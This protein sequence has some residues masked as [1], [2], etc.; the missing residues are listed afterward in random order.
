MK[1]IAPALRAVAVPLFAALLSTSAQ[2]ENLFEGLENL[3]GDD[4]PKMLYT[5][6]WEELKPLNKPSPVNPNHRESGGHGGH[7][8]MKNFENGLLMTPPDDYWVLYAQAHGGRWSDPCAIHYTVASITERRYHRQSDFATLYRPTYRAVHLAENREYLIKLMRKFSRNYDDNP[9]G[10]VKM[11]RCE[12]G[13]SAP[14]RH[15]EDDIRTEPRTHERNYRVRC[16]FQHPRVSKDFT[17]RGQSGREAV[18]WAENKL[19]GEAECVAIE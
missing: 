16:T 1:G 10:V 6:Q 19:G 13:E 3:F 18:A 7:R 15:F 17:I 11:R 4:E 12:Y 2:A 9:D 8:P 5:P 14:N